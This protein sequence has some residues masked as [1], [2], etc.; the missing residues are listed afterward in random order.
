MPIYDYQCTECGTE[1]FRVV[2][3][4]EPLPCPNCEGMLVWIEAPEFSPRASPDE[5]LINRDWLIQENAC[6]PGLL[7]F[8]QNYGNKLIPASWVTAKLIAQ[9]RHNWAG[10]LI[11][12]L[13]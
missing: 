11:R 9:R 2:D 6:S 13:P 12:H 3:Q 8:T 1:D 7:W 10:W 4:P 5:P